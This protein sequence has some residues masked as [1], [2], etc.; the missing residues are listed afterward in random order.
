MRRLEAGGDGRLTDVGSA[1]ASQMLGPGVA[2]DADGDGDVDVAAKEALGLGFGRTATFVNNAGS[3]TPG[4]VVN[5]QGPIAAADFDGDGRTDLC[6]QQTDRLQLWRRVVAGLGYTQ[7]ITFAVTG[8][9]SAADL[10]QDGDVDLLGNTTT[11]NR[12]FT[13]PMAGERRQYGDGSAG[14]GGARPLLSLVG[15]LRSGQMPSIRIV[16]GLGGSAGAL[17]VSTAEANVPDVLPG[18]TSWIGPGFVS[19]GIALG[20]ATGQPGAGAAQLPL[21]IPP[22][23]N[24]TRLFLQFLALDPTAPIGLTHSNGCELFVGL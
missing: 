20:G 17:F 3:F 4:P 16:G 24:G 9:T 11:W 19:F 1:T 13:M 15:P 12:R 8:V 5:S 21:V 18:I 7:A 10:D 2:D 14:T 23:A 6:V 22:A